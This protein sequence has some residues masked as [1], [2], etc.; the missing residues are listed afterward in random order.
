MGHGPAS[1]KLPIHSKHL[2]AKFA[3]EPIVADINNQ[4][5]MHGP[6]VRLDVGIQAPLTVHA[7]AEFTSEVT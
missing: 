7:Y 3:L 2:F 6:W 1:A 5:G 4:K